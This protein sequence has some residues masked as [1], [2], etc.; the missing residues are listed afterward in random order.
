M[1]NEQF[2]PFSN[3]LT[4]INELFEQFVRHKLSQRIDTNPLSIKLSPSAP[5]SFAAT[6]PL[7]LSILP[8]RM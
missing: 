8:D 4:V 2:Q 5:R 3:V 7:L 6:N 1:I